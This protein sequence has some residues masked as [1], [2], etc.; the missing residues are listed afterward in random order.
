MIPENAGEW[1]RFFVWVGLYL[2]MAVPLLG[3]IV[4]QVDQ[5][6][7]YDVPRFSPEELQQLGKRP[8]NT[9]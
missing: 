5:Q 4:R 6:E 2:L 1:G 7:Q 9:P 3:W 8:K